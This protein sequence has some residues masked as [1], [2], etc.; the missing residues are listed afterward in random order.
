MSRIF[1]TKKRKDVFREL[2]RYKVKST[3]LPRS[4]STAKNSALVALILGATS[5]PVLADNW[6]WNASTTDNKWRTTAGSTSNIST[7]TF[8]ASTNLIWLTNANG[9][10]N[11][12]AVFSVAGG[13]TV[14]VSADTSGTNDALNI[15]ANGLIFNTTGY[16]FTTNNFRVGAGGVDTTGLASGGTV[17]FGDSGSNGGGL[18][19]TADQTWKL[20]AGT[21][22]TANNWYQGG[23]VTRLNN[24]GYN[25]TLNSASGTT[26][27]NAT[28]AGTGGL[29]KTGAGN[30]VLGS[31]TANFTGNVDIQE[32]TLTVAASASSNNG[33]RTALGQ[34][35]SGTKTITVGSG[36]T[37]AG[38]TNDWFGN[39]TATVLPTITVNGGSLTTTSYTT[40]GNLNLNGASVSS[41]S[42]GTAS[43]QGFAF[44]GTVTVGGS[45][46]STI[47]ATGSGASTYGYHLG[48]NTEF[49]V[50][51]AT[52]S[53]A[54]DLTV[55]AAL[56]NQSLGFSSAA[57]GLT[58]TGAGTMVLSGANTYTGATA[59]SAGTLLI[60]GST[61]GS[62]VS[63]ASGAKLGGTGTVNGA[64]S[65]A[66]G[67][68]VV[69]GAGTA[70]S[71]SLTVAGNLSLLDSS[72]I[73][74]V[75]GSGLTHSSLVR[76]SGT[77]VFDADQLFV[78][79]GTGFT[80]GTYQNIISGLTGTETGLSTIGSWTISG[81]VQGTFTYDGAGGV[82]LQVTT[83]PEPGTWALVA[84][85]GMMVTIIARRR[86]AARQ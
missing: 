27:V 51:D 73:E 6:T 48:A 36:A 31:G 37:L 53:S 71:G 81:G 67:G 72:K 68:S 62:A 19:F 66:G 76:T 57:G 77:W 24:N 29:T 80:V 18:I 70:A 45:L 85:G 30:V 16:V 5:F 32:G 83:V 46:A 15:Y 21:T 41:S 14:A 4:L 9:A 7:W 11:N 10:G 54:A 47:S 44:R 26:T 56:R 8:G 42:A 13:Y 86:K 12:N 75:L 1:F 39:A 40:I 78:F 22:I 79:T 43:Y 38:T 35:S 23:A 61:S 59:V 55:S 34:G 3:P 84:L 58:K 60:N 50:A 25:L 69:G 64:V 52:G 49:N 63:V 65:V 2:N 33:D 74:L 28:L 20:G 82:D 17:V